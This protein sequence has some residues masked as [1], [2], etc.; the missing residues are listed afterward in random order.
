M[1]NKEQTN[2]VLEK[3]FNAC[4]NYWKLTVND[5]RKAFAN[6]I[7]DIRHM[8]HDPFTMSGEEIDIDTRDK[9]VRYREQDLGA[10]YG[11]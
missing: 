5:D 3:H 1:L 10:G 11:R 8:H 4:Y 2:L 6:A 9:F 7:E